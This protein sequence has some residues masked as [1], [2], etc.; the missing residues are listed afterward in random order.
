MSATFNIRD[1]YAA[2]R[3]MVVETYSEK[4]GLLLAVVSHLRE[5]IERELRSPR[6]SKKKLV[7]LLAYIDAC[8]VPCDRFDAA[9]NRISS[10]RP[11]REGGE[12]LPASLPSARLAAARDDELA[13]RIAL[14][15]E[16]DPTATRT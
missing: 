11:Q 5:E 13:D 14:A 2:H 15:M 3:A 12:F 4:S 6:P 8:M 1:P 9:L 7:D 16:A 10:E